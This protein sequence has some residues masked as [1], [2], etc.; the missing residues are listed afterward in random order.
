MLHDNA[1]VGFDGRGMDEGRERA[2]QGAAPHIGVRRIAE[3]KLKCAPLKNGQRAL[4]GLGNDP[5]LL[6]ESEGLDVCADRQEGIAA[7]LDE[8]GVCG[9]ARDG[10]QSER[11]RSRVKIEDPRFF[12]GT[13][14]GQNAEN[15]L[16]DAIR[17]G[18]RFDAA[19]GA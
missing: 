15:G 5:D 8:G 3:N 16:P 17:R 7:P 2:G 1:R 10:F 4:Y 13:R 18:A 14:G 19:R 9:P 12:N 6:P 11:P